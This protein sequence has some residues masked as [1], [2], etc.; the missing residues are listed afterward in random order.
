MNHLSDYLLKFK[1]TLFRGQEIRE[2]IVVI[3]KEVVGVEIST[4]NVEIRNQKLKI[5]TH[6]VIKNELK[7]KKN[8]IILRIS[9]VL[10]KGVV[11]EII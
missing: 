6:S 2:G 1:K 9:E 3:I 10:G 8:K 7:L 4:K 5:S 11:E